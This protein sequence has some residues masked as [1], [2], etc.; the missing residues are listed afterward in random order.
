MFL[1]DQHHISSQV[2]LVRGFAWVGSMIR[3]VSAKE[4]AERYC[5][6]AAALWPGLDILPAEY[7]LPAAPVV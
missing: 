4:V 6:T 5:C 2:V 1:L 7:I 3:Q